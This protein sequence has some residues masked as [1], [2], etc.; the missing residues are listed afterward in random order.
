MIEGARRKNDTVKIFFEKKLGRR[1]YRKVSYPL[2]NRS[3]RRFFNVRGII[4]RR[5]DGFPVGFVTG[6]NGF[7]ADRP[8]QS[9]WWPRRNCGTVAE[10]AVQ[11]RIVAF[12]ER[13]QEKI[14]IST[15][16]SS[17]RLNLASPPP[18][19]NRRDI[20]ANSGTSP[21][22]AFSQHMGL[23]FHPTIWTRTRL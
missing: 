9:G 2:N 13:G 17:G 10:A 15:R 20:V 22:R 19:L 1:S 12:L 18:P 4:K 8:N 14:L 11:W 5:D 6:L 7:A 23:M 3:R 16:S 21:M